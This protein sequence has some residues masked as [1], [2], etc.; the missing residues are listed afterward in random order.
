MQASDIVEPLDKVFVS[1]KLED[2]DEM[3]LEGA[4]LPN[5]LNR[6]MTDPL[7]RGHTAD[8]PMGGMRRHLGQ[9]GLDIRTDFLV[10]NTLDAA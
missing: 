6:H 9:G 1:A 10:R 8:A 3:R 4:L 2:L 5:T 7:G